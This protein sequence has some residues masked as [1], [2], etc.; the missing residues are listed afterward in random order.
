MESGSL[1]AW[2]APTSAMD[3]KAYQNGNVFL[4]VPE[5]SDQAASVAK[6]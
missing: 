6:L 2:A 4:L 5:V 3:W 1:A